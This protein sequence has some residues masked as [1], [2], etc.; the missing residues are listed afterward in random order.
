MKINLNPMNAKPHT[1]AFFSGLSVLLIV[2]FSIY[3]FVK[4][5][6]MEIEKELVKSNV[7]SVIAQI[8]QVI[9]EANGNTFTSPMEKAILIVENTKRLGNNYSF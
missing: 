8:D 4:A 1:M 9:E 5:D 3:V 7:D 2:L 6:M